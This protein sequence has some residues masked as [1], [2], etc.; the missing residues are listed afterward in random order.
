MH[1][2]DTSGNSNSYFKT[3]IHPSLFNKIQS[4]K[5]PTLRVLNVGM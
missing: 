4:R 5:P 3:I 2:T 1:F